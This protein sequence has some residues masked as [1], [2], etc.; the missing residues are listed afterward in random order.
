MSNIPSSL[1]EVCLNPLPPRHVRRR[2]LAIPLEKIQT[3]S[4]PLISLPLSSF[5]FSLSSTQPMKRIRGFKLKHRV[6]MLF[7][8]A[9]RGSRSGYQR[10]DPEKRGP[11]PISWL[12][13][14]LKA[15]AKSLCSGYSGRGY[16]PLGKVEPVPKGQMAVYVGGGD[17]DGVHRVVV[18][19]IYFNHP[20]FG[21]LLREAEEV[22][23]YNHP[24]GLTIPCRLSEF[25]R[26]RTHVAAARG[27]RKLLSWKRLSG[28]SFRV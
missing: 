28:G 25:E 12:L 20:L 18:P 7:R 17:G 27:C 2:P 19:V 4:P 15:K 16:V 1:S 13:T 24:G 22:Y 21:E 23:G 3:L 14:S 10:V 26:V 6:A 8:F 5:V 9:L 11:R